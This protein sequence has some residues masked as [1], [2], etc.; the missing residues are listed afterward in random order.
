MHTRDG[1][2]LIELMIASALLLVLVAGVTG[3]FTS[4]HQAHHAPAKTP[5][6]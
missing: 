6:P 1:F 4:Q 2:T 5:M 3:V